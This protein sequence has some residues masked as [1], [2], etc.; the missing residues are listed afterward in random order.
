M[1]KL[2]ELGMK[3]LP[4]EIIVPTGTV[5]NLGC[6]N[7]HIPGTI[8]LDLPSWDAEQDPIPYENESVDGIYAFHFLEHLSGKDTINILAECQRVLKVGG[9]MTVCVPHRLGA[10]AFQDL[11]HK[12]FWTEESWKTLF[13]N[14]YYD[15]NRE[16]P[17]KFDIRFNMIMGRNERNLALFTQLAKFL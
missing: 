17:W 6:G 5:L 8:G 1:R 16:K 12:S 4:N 9:V 10:M 11:D 2:F 13:T 3:F 7:S 15:K 14:G